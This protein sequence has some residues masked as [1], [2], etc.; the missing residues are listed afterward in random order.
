MLKQQTQEPPVPI[1]TRAGIAS[2]DNSATIALLEHWVAVDATDDPQVIAQA[3][4]DLA[5]LMASLNAN[6]P[7]NSPMFP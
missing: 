5:D 7:P 4:R 3:E 1:D 6:R 2:A